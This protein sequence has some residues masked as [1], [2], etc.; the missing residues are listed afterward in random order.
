MWVPSKQYQVLPMP[1]KMSSKNLKHVYYSHVRL[2]ILL[3]PFL[4]VLTCNFSVK[5][6]NMKHC[7]HMAD[8]NPRPLDLKEYALSLYYGVIGYFG[9]LDTY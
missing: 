3:A 7:H 1:R 4:C 2:V 9:A 6:K 5:S 8:P